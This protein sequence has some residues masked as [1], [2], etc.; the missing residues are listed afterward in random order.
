VP[1]K[2]R[3]EAEAWLLAGEP[4]SGVLAWHRNWSD[5]ARRP[6]ST[7]RAAA[8]AL[9]S[10]VPVVQVARVRAVEQLLTKLEAADAPAVG[11]P[12]RKHG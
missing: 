12:K 5:T 9:V 6:S 3:S 1:S 7:A 4:V 11:K 2:S 10:R 8:V